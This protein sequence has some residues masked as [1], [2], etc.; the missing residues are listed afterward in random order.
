MPDLKT[1]DA[2]QGGA[3]LTGNVTAIEAGEHVISAVFLGETPL[4]A[5]ADGALRIG[6]ET[7]AC[8][9][10]GI[11]VAASDGKRIL[12]GGDD[13]RVIA[14]D[15]SGRSEVMGDE[16]NRWIDA[17]A[18]GPDGTCAWSTGKSVKARDGKGVIKTLAT[19]SSTQGLAFRP[20]G[21]QL[22]AAQNGGALI[23]MPNA[24]AAPDL[25]EWKGSHLDVVWSPDARY[26]IT[27]MQE[28][29][30][31]GWRL[32]E[33]AHMR[34]S[35]YPTKPRS[36][37]WSMDGNWLATSGAEAAIVWPFASKD[38]PMGKAP[39]ECGVR[40]RR[41]SQVAFHPKALVLAIGYEDGFI[42]L[43]RLTDASEIL[44][45][46]QTR[47]EAVTALGWDRSGSRLLFGTADGAAGLLTLPVGR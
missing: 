16:Q 32:P 4:L 12:T 19:K 36:M 23:W 15:A 1:P 10:G 3:S 39:R 18:L 27:S 46:G 45:R 14:T 11:L 20:K 8:H 9:K 17:V 13:G 30:L 22:A 7:I 24:L 34:M 33:K 38:G 26:V 40:N 47:G 5:L 31:H 44:V 25:L 6:D 43:V 28:N 35:G 21:Y 29:Q 41:V 37:S 42:L 2:L